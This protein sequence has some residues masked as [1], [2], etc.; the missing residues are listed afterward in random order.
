MGDNS[1]V[2]TAAATDRGLVRPV[3]EDC[4]LADSA[5]G[6]L[7]VADGMGGHRGGEVASRMAVSAVYRSLR[8]SA[9]LDPI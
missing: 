5:G 6:V 4:V 3:N 8:D 9:G 1:S 7:I 2:Q